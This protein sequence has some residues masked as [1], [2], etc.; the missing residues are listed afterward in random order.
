MET[1]EQEIVIKDACILFDLTDLDILEEYFQLELKS[2][3]TPQVIAEITNETQWLKISKFVNNGNLIIDSDGEIL[4]ISKIY[5][6]FPGLS[7]TDSS[8][9]ELA[10][11]KDAVILSSDGSLRRISKK[12]NLKI[13]G[14]LWVIEELYNTKIM[15]VEIVIEKLENYMKIN[16]RAPKEEIEKLIKKIS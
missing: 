7:F 15:K 6:Q 4:T 12:K 10:L 8:V 14:L 5:E 1:S 16:Q 9:L 13:K 2:F 11:R 3:T